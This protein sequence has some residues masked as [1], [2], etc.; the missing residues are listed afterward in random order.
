MDETLRIPFTPDI[1][2]ERTGI[3]L[4]HTGKEGNVLVVLADSQRKLEDTVFLLT[5]GFFRE[6]LLGD[7]V[8][9]YPDP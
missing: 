2:R 1:E 8:G 6:G 3:I 9:V 4:L 7:F 5:S